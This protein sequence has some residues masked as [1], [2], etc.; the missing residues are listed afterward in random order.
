AGREPLTGKLSLLSWQ[1]KVVTLKAADAVDFLVQ[2]P[3]PHQLP[4]GFAL[5]A[6]LAFW[7]QA[8]LLAINLLVG[9]RY[10]P[11]LE[12]HGSRYAA[13]WNPQ[14]AA[15][16]LAQ[17]GAAMP[18]LCR[19]MTSAAQEPPQVHALLQ[20]FLRTAVDS[21]VREA[22][23]PTRKPTKPWLKALLD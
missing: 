9:Q 23:S 12:Q 15:D 1:L 19:A 14:P 17:F 7:Q 8:A 11:A 21:I 18:G 2:L 13:Y 3:E 10:I 6:D 16:I 5:G 22:Y 4:G 20:D